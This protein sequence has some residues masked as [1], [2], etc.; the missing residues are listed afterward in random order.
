MLHLFVV[1]DSV[2]TKG[3]A[4]KDK[5]KKQ[6]AASGQLIKFSVIQDLNKYYLIV[7][8]NHDYSSEVGLFYAVFV[9]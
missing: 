1:T 6:K 2:L 7:F 4:D 3:E 8:I 5:N 9:L